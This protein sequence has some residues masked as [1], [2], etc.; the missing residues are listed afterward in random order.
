MEEISKENFYSFFFFLQKMYLQYCL[1]YFSDIKKLAQELNAGEPTMKLI[2]DG[3]LQ[4]INYDL[5]DGKSEI[6]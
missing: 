3:L 2:V 5:R 4:P 6:K 1:I